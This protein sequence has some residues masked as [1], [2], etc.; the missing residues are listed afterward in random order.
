MKEPETYT[1][2]DGEPW[3]YCAVCLSPNIQHEDIT[4]FDCCK[5][6][7]ST[8]IKETTI[9]NW[10]A[11]YEKR[12][13][14]KYNEEVGDPRKS[15]IFKLPLDKLMSKVFNCSKWKSIISSIYSGF[16]S[17]LSKAD[18]IVVF[19]DKLVK[20]GLLDK[21]RWLLYNMKI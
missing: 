8:N 21:L 14:K 9:E 5:D 2:Y 10:E 19:F 3:Y 6:C 17:G 7:G 13:G 1:D 12:Y 11:L 16:P 18:S 15:P 20:D 4:D